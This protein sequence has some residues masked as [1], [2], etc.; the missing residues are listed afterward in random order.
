MEAHAMRRDEAQCSKCGVIKRSYLM[1]FTPEGTL[2][3]DCDPLLQDE[4]EP[5]TQDIHLPRR[6]TPDSL[7]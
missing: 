1:V 4:G 7:S 5:I 2:C 3:T 6:A